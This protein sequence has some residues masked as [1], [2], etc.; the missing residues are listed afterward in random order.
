MFINPYSFVPLP[1]RIER[2]KPAGH[3]RAVEGL[4]S[5]K[6]EVEATALTP[7]LIRGEQQPD[8]SW[9]LP[10]RN[11]VPYIPGSSIHGALRSLHEAMA[12][13]CMRVFDETFLPVYRQ[14]VQQPGPAWHPA[15]VSVADDGAV[16]VTLC[17]TW[18]DEDGMHDDVIHVDVNCLGNDPEQVK[19]GALLDLDDA[20]AGLDAHGNYRIDSRADVQ[21][22][23]GGKWV[24]HVTDTRT[25]EN[26]PH[27]LF[28]VFPIGTRKYEVPSSVLASFK[29]LA[30]GA[31]DLRPGAGLTNLP[32][33]QG[34]KQVPVKRKGRTIG[35]R[36]KVQPRPQNGQ[37][38]WAKVAGDRVES[39]SLAQV[40]R[41]LGEGPVSER[42]PSGWYE[43]GKATPKCTD[44]EHLCISCRLFGSID[45]TKAEQDDAA[46]QRSYRGQVRVL[47]SLVDGVKPIQIPLPPLGEPR[48]GAGQFYLE[49]SGVLPQ[50][51]D[52]TALRQWGSFADQQT[53]RRIRGRKMY[54]ANSWQTRSPRAHRAGPATAMSSD[55][56]AFPEGTA[57]TFTVVFENLTGSELGSLLSALAPSEWAATKALTDH[58]TVFRLGGGKPLGFG[59][60]TTQVSLSLEPTKPQ[61]RWLPAAEQTDQPDNQTGGSVADFVHEFVDNAPPEVRTDWQALANLL[62]VDFVDGTDVQYPPPE[63]GNDFGFW[64]RSRGI[65]EHNQPHQLIPLPNPADCTENSQRID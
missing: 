33:Y 43:N 29:V 53:L 5:G 65:F 38:V 39:L 35:Y 13:G 61:E 41:E 48:P 64:K 26:R 56:T 24:L 9:D 1:E 47:D 58:E 46:A 17:D 36:D 11:G 63:G 30:M 7:L 14:L 31:D 34:R 3:A 8:D 50:R 57:F 23:D 44:P 42:L 51:G 28:L 18:T 22:H 45:A 37:V 16:W 55:A 62:S 2:A 40:W 19:S 32:E 10:R 59:A 4:L 12:G 21:F 25:R 60:L 15:V 27:C 54:W 6:I 49:E 52:R 20:Q